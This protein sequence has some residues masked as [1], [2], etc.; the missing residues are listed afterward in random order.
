M[1]DSDIRKLK[2]A[3]EKNLKFFGK[4]SSVSDIFVECILSEKPLTYNELSERTGYSIASISLALKGYMPALNVFTKPGSKKKYVEVNLDLINLKINQYK[5][6]KKEMIE[7]M[8]ESLTSLSKK[9]KY[10]SNENI[11]KKINSLRDQ[12]KVINDLVDI[13]L[14]YLGDYNEKSK[15]K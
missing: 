8:V 4:P 2:Q 13:S 6:I 9:E 12:T 15:K 3:M 1:T 11:S 14:K 7:P 10:I 5:M